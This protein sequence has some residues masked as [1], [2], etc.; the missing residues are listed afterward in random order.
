MKKHILKDNNTYAQNVDT[1]P[2]VYCRFL[3]LDHLRKIRGLFFSAL[4]FIV[5]YFFNQSLHDLMLSLNIHEALIF[6]GF[7]CPCSAGMATYAATNPIH[8]IFV[9]ECIALKSPG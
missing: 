7:I 1:M 2:I 8:L 3:S 5:C 6:I 4:H 9:R